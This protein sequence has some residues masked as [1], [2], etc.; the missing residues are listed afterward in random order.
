MIFVSKG[1]PQT[2]HSIAQ[3]VLQRSLQLPRKSLLTGL[4][5][6]THGQAIISSIKV[7]LPVSTTTSS[8][9]LRWQ[10]SLK[11]W[12]THSEETRSKCNHQHRQ[13]RY[14]KRRGMTAAAH[15]KNTNKGT[16]A[17]KLKLTLFFVPWPFGLGNS[18][19]CHCVCEERLCA[20]IDMCRL[21]DC[22]YSE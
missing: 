12:S 1:H 11:T 8:N 18:F 16:G 3:P 5:E 9:L 13:R 21:A 20:S 14:D 22:C 15:S 19:I 6:S 4:H 7:S 17:F 2:C 10:V